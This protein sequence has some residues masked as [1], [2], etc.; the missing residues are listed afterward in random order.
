MMNIQHQ[1]KR[2]RFRM[3][4]NNLLPNKEKDEKVHNRVPLCIIFFALTDKES[5]AI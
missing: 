1:K 3:I 2:G 4:Q 5:I